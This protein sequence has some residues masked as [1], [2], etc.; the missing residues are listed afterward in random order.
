MERTI[1]LCCNLAQT[2]GVFTQL[3]VP[4]PGNVC[5]EPNAKS[6]G[7]T[8]LKSYNGRPQCLEWL[9]FIGRIIILI[10]LF[11]IALTYT[12]VN[13]HHFT[14][15]HIFTDAEF[16]DGPFAG[17]AASR[18]FL[19]YLYIWTW[20]LL[21]L[22]TTARGSESTWLHTCGGTHGGSDRPPDGSQIADKLLCVFSMFDMVSQ[23]SLCPND[24]EQAE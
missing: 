20:H 12:R 21:G 17:G 5:T 9:F 8:P 4:H 3:S 13:K 11:P 10:R 15:S 7:K 19:P 16:R 22:L 6:V 14:E 18:R 24:S 23:S 1:F 2:A